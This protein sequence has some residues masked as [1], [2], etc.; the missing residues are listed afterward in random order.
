MKF[1]KCQ[2]GLENVLRNQ[3]YSNDKCGL[4]FS[5]LDKPNTTKTI[6]VKATIKFNNKESKKVHFLDY[7]KRPYDR[8]NF[9]LN[10]R[11]NVFRPICFNCNAKGHTSNTC[12][13]KNYGIPYCEY[14]WVRK[15]SN[16]RGPKKYWVSK[17][18]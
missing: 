12:Y 4:D 10:K 1:E 2:I 5:N 15:G 16:P 6:F 9:Y 7:H 17:Y 8:N 13:I 14:V 3:R 18:Y 11:N